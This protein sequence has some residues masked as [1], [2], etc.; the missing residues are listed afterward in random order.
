M[1]SVRYDGKEMAIST[2]ATTFCAGKGGQ[3][4]VAVVLDKETEGIHASHDAVLERIFVG[5]QNRRPVNTS[6]IQ[7]I[8]PTFQYSE[9]V[10]KFN[11]HGYQ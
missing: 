5:H 9:E 10:E 6:I 1:G 2:L 7:V 11:I 8:A 3:D 4:S